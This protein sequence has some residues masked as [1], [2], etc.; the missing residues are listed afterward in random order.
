LVTVNELPDLLPIYGQTTT[1]CAGSTTNL[2]NGNMGG[3]WSSSN[4]SLA[5]IDPYSGVVTANNMGYSGFL[6]ISYSL[7]MYGCTNSVST[8]LT[9]KPL[10]T[11]TITP[12]TS[13]TFCQGGSVVLTASSGST[14]L[15]RN[16]SS[17]V[18]TGS[19]DTATAA[20]SYTVTVTGSNG[21]SATSTATVVTIKEPTTSTSTASACVSYEWN[22]T[23]YTTSGTKTWV[24]INAAGCDST[25]TLNLT[26]KQ[27]T[28]STA[29]ASACVSYEWNGTTYTTSG[30]KTWLGTNAAGCDS[31]ATLNLTIKEPT[32]STSTASACISYE[33]NGTNYTTSGAKT[34]LG[35]N[36]AG[37]DSTATL[38]LTIKEPTTSI[39]TASACVS[40]VW[41][42]T[43]YTTSGAKTWSGT[44][45]AGCDSTATLNLTI[46]EP[47]TSTSTASAC[48]SY[49]WNGITYTTSGTKTWV[50]TNAAGCDS[51]ATL[52]LTIKQPTTST[53]TVSTCVSYE[54]NG[55][56]YTTSGAKT[57]VGINAAGCDSTATLN[58]TI[59]VP[60]ASTS[61]AS[62]C[63]SYEWNGTIYTTSG[64]K[65]WVGTNAAGC[66]S[67]AT[68]NLTIK[69]PTTSTT[70]ASSCVSY[71]WNGITYTTSGTYTW[72][73]TNAAGCDST[74]TLNL[75]IKEPTTST[76]T[77]SVCVSYAWNGTTYTTSGPKTWVGINAAGCDS[78]A[79]LNL[80]IKVPTTSTASVTACGSYTWNN[81][82]YTTSGPKTWVGT[83]AA[84]CDSTATLVLT[85]TPIP[86]QPTGLACWETATLNTSTCSWVVS[87][88]E[89]AQP[90][91]TVKV[92]LDGYYKTASNPGLMR[93]ARYTNL[94]ESGSLNP[95]A[96]TD[97]DLI[98]VELV[99]PSN[100]YGVAY[101]ISPILQ[102]NGT[103]QCVFP[104]C[105]LYGS[106]YIV[107]K[108]RA[109]IPIWSANPITLSTT[110]TYNFSNNLANVYAQ[111]NVL[112][113]TMHTINSG[114]YGMWMGE[115]TDDDFLDAVDYSPYD[116]D[117]YLSGYGGLYLLDGDFN[118]D[119]YVDAVDYGSVFD[120]NSNQGVYTQRPYGIPTLS[121]VTTTAVS[122]ITATSA[123]SGGAV[124]SSGNAILS[125]W[126]ICWSTSPNPTIANSFSQNNVNSGGFSSALSGLTQNTTYYVRA[127][128]TNSAGTAYGNE[129][130]FTTLTI[131]LP[132]VTTTAVSAITT[133]SASSGG[134]VTSNGNGTLSAW[135][136][137]WGTS[138]N[139]TLGNSSLQNTNNS[140]GFSSALSG[141]TASTIYYVRAYA[142]NSAGTAY[143]NQVSFTTAY[144]P[145]SIGQSYQ[146]GKVAYILQAG[147]PGYD[148]S[149]QHGLIAAPSDN[150]KDNGL[151]AI[152]GCQGTAV[153]TASAIGSG[154]QNTINILTVCN[155]QHIA[156]RLCGDLVLGG[157]SD[158]Y[159]PSKDE[160]NKLYINRIAIGGFQ[161]LW[162]WSS[163]QSSQYTPAVNSHNAWKQNFSTGA[164][165]DSFGKNGSFSPSRA[166]RS[167]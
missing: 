154:A 64:A 65:T 128:A 9:I 138:P 127:Y 78:T 107:V 36:A 68:L 25:A 74:A 89:P 165:V 131:V 63:V 56:N 4:T 1:I 57:W 160:L 88:S 49:E 103:V 124:T 141:L 114:L 167:F 158:W 19:T 69:V 11:A 123:S 153:A 112:I 152:W 92:F 66:D 67:T 33:W 32:T 10:P 43:T 130:S 148:A 129:V 23:N 106:Y 73:G 86:A 22:G 150:V 135:G 118:G 21:C 51:T 162:Y 16:G 102:T 77:A 142:T 164:Q 87:G 108:H 113:P 144:I 45:A 44:N 137:C 120:Y 136:V 116:A 28:T 80:T 8:S 161:N 62:A 20:G 48:V 98:T 75:T 100:L 13:T 146:G 84:G 122:A 94:V 72:V 60:T 83:N 139:P 157:Y 46:K 38:N 147:D 159:L 26:I 125:A 59:K 55:T 95:G 71:A 27:P 52:N 30:A 7:T 37:C 17:T 96:A 3:T 155:Q 143:G 126:G 109:A 99:S 61:T 151:D 101:S 39:S 18:G 2:Y 97:V 105:A 70:T 29:S 110:T 111:S 132:I 40:Y 12:A 90:V 15:W 53:S 117:V 31:T 82:N 133:T 149:V 119:S 41:N 50:G 34:W 121:T 42:G 166:V 5:N 140:G 79:T 145:L 76:T 134:A 163:S 81:T 104:V 14:Y 35:T 54:W 93:P 115:M 24:G 6:G 156:A 91:L 58:L 85:I 47:T